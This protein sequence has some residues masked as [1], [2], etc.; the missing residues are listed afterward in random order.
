MLSN[1]ITKVDILL[2]LIREEGGFRKFMIHFDNAAEKLYNIMKERISKLNFYWKDENYYFKFVEMQDGI[3]VTLHRKEGE[4]LKFAYQLTPEI[5]FSMLDLSPD[6]ILVEVN[7]RNKDV[8][9]Y[10]RTLK[11]F[12]EITKYDDNLFVWKI[13]G[14]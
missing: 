8:V 2:A 4:S 3:V 5:D 7:D 14:I 10:L 6:E 9:E 12:S 11:F 13:R 1:K